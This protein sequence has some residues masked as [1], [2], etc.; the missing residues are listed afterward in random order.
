MSVRALGRV[1]LLR[2]VDERGLGEL[3][4]AAVPRSVRG[5]RALYVR[6]DVASSLFVVLAGRVALG[7]RPRGRSA[8]ARTEVRGEARGGATFGEEGAAAGGGARAEDAWAAEDSRVLEI[9]GALVRR[10]IER[11]GRAANLERLERRARRRALGAALVDVGI[12]AH[13]GDA[14]SAADRARSARTLDAARIRGAAPGERVSLDAEIAIV[15]SGAATVDVRARIGAESAAGAGALRGEATATGAVE[16]R[17]GPGDVAVPPDVAALRMIL[18]GRLALVPAAFVDAARA[19]D[20]AARARVRLTDR[21]A[22][23]LETRRLGRAPLDPGRIARAGSLLV[24]D[25]EA[26]VRCGHC[27]VACAEA[28]VD[29]V[30]RL[31]RRGDRVLLPLVGDAGARPTVPAPVVAV[32]AASCQHCVDAP[33]L[34][35]CPTGALARAAAGLVQIDAPTCTGCGQ[36]A[37]SCPY[38]AVQI[39]PAPTGGPT[40]ALLARKC[41]G[42]ASVA[43]RATVGGPACVAACP[44]AALTRH[45]VGTTDVGPAVRGRPALARGARAHA[46]A[47]AVGL[48]CAA[49]V[50]GALAGAG[51]GRVAAGGVAFA[52][53]AATGVLSAV[54]RGRTPR[55]ALGRAPAA[56]LVA[57]VG[58][59]A[60]AALLAHEA[61]GVLF[62]VAVVA[63]A[64]PVR[65]TPLGLAL[66]A[67]SAAT[68]V[69]GAAGLVGALTIPRRLARL[70]GAHAETPR[71]ARAREERRVDAVFAAVSG[72]SPTVKDAYARHLE[73]TLRGA[74]AAAWEALGGE[75]RATEARL[76][77]VVAG[78]GS[79][80]NAGDVGD[81]GDEQGRLAALARLAAEAAAARAAR[82]LEAALAVATGVHV[83]CASALLA[84]TLAHA[85]LATLALR[86]TP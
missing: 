51:A 4:A 63:H 66:L 79:A 25:E 8:P 64:R 50:G 57:R 55:S 42:C 71:A 34:A 23:A 31:E 33:C 77:R 72:A 44:S 35:G 74:R 26:C 70:A 6:G 13:G 3:A 5:G 62:A 9:P 56:A 21:A 28:H 40:G 65:G 41:D 60:R 27:V 2:G 36:C 22:L 82:W 61:L 43:T 24:L 80:V 19:A 59:P 86:G 15:L 1:P 49:L 47:V 29:G 73:P 78:R 16:V 38:G 53:L 37:R 39:G 52:A 69:T 18:P 54:K 58:T 32:L 48:A 75:G 12:L 17:L 83:A 20:V 30:P 85:V 46:V 84:A 76:R 11:A 67:L 14:D 7:E 81:V 68:V 45:A 10:V